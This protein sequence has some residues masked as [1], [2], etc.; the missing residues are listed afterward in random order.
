MK[1]LDN[2]TGTVVEICSAFPNKAILEFAHAENSG[3]AILWSSRLYVKGK[4]LPSH[5][6][7]KDYLNVGFKVTFSCHMYSN[8]NNDDCQWFVISAYSSELDQRELES[9]GLHTLETI[10]GLKNQTGVITQI[11]KR[12]AIISFTNEKSKD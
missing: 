12:Q 1:S 2:I 3:R 7:I 5:T 9:L 8:P 6:H 4:P 10:D 11:T